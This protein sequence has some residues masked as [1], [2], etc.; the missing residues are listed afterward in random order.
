MPESRHTVITSILHNNLTR[1]VDI[2]FPSLW[3]MKLR[4]LVEVTL[5]VMGSSRVGLEQRSL[6]RV[7]CSFTH[8]LTPP[9]EMK[10]CDPWDGSWGAGP[11]GHNGLCT[12]G[13]AGITGGY[14]DSY[15]LAATAVMAPSRAGL[16]TFPPNPPPTLFMW[17][18]ILFLG[19]FNAAATNSCKR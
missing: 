11:E 3:V 6:A 1:Q 19:T 15:L 17:Q 2:I 13:T 5:W 10:G 7:Q 9:L 4:W 16:V 12:V 8:T 18:A 14:C